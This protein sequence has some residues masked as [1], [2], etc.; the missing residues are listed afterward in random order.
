MDLLANYRPGS[1]DA[2]LWT[3][4][5]EF[6]EL[7]NRDTYDI[8]ALWK[9]VKENGIL[10]PILLGDDGRVWDGHHRLTVANMMKLEDVPTEQGGG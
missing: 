3:W 10:E 8:L 6:A 4:E 2:T 5:E 7:F 1:Y 9:S